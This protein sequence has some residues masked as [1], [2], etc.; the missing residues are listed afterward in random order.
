[1]KTDYIIIAGIILLGIYFL[2][3]K[4]YIL[5]NFESLTP[6]QAYEMLKK[7]DKNITIVDVRTPEEQ[8][9]GTLKKAR[10]IPVHELKA[11]LGQLKDSQ[12]KMI[13]VYCASGM[14]SVSAARMLSDNNFTV[15]NIKGGI[16]GW[17][18]ANLP[19]KY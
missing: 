1:M 13:F 18:G 5:A 12:N 19:L 9:S 7:G 4:G 6:E 3:K 15:Y 10:L 8:R 11:K 14:R 17:K 2:Y 16:E